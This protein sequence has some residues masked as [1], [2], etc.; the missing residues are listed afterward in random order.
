MASPVVRTTKYT[1]RD[2]RTPINSHTEYNIP[3]LYS[4][5]F[6]SFDDQRRFTMIVII[7][8]LMAASLK[9]TTGTQFSLLGGQGEFS[10]QGQT[11]G[12][13]TGT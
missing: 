11:R 1:V 2:N 5:F 13:Y 9:R 8:V 3:I 4:V 10:S 12:L 7:P 6:S